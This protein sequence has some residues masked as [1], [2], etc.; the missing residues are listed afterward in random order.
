MV[1]PAELSTTITDEDTT[2][3]RFGTEDVLTG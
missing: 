2:D 3:P 1:T